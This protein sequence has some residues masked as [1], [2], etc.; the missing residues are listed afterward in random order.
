RDHILRLAFILQCKYSACDLLVLR[1]EN[2]RTRRRRWGC[3]NVVSSY[4]TVNYTA[5]ELWAIAKERKV[6]HYTVYEKSEFAKIL[7]IDSVAFQL[8][9]HLHG[10]K[11]KKV[12]ENL[13]IREE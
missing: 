8:A 3:S 7:R 4:A 6:P 10:G 13:Q 12:T 11:G 9:S 5:R 2:D 1:H